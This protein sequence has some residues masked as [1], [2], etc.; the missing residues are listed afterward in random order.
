PVS[1]DVGLLERSP[2]VAVVPGSF[3]WDDVGTW[4]ALARVRRRDR[5]GNVAVGTVHFHDS[6]D[7]IVWSDAEPVVLSGVRDLVVVRANGRILVMP[8]RQAADLKSLLDDL[9][10]DI[11]EL[12]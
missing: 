5:E 8:R 7:C 3:G 4:D 1:I 12:E 2:A 11:R 10:S 6:Q 9:P